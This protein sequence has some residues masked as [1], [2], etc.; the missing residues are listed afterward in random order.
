MIEKVKP[1]VCFRETK[2]RKQYFSDK[3][4]SFTRNVQEM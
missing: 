2:Y 4:M 1:D 3:L